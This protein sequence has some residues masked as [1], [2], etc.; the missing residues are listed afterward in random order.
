MNTIRKA[1]AA[2]A[3]VALGASQAG[4]AVIFSE[5]F[6][7]VGGLVAAGW[8]IQNLSTPGGTTEWFQGNTGVFVAHSGP[9][10]SYLASNFL[11]APSGGD[12][13]LYIYSPVLLLQ[14]GDTI[15]F[16]TRTDAG[17]ADFGDSLY[18]GLLDGGDGALLGINVGN[19]IGGYP[20]E[21]T[22]YSAV[23][24]GFGGPGLL[25]FGFLYTGPADVLNYI[26][27]DSVEV[28]RPGTV[29]EPGSLLLLGLGLAGLGLARRRKG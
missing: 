7:D 27:I 4:A 3:L 29:P 11:A 26:G 28:V 12:V 2:T 9:E 14:P 6:D 22:Q 17:G 24:E 13:D 20:T 25:R 18:L 8:V 1:L 19:G 10:D 21:W 23:L 5:G 15:S 16:W